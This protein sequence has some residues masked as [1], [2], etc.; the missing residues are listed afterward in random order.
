MLDTLSRK[1][2]GKT[3]QKGGDRQLGGGYHEGVSWAQKKVQ[4]EKPI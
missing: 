3:M 4:P 2:G 1:E